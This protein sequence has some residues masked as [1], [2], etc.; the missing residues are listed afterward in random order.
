MLQYTIDG[1]ETVHDVNMRRTENGQEVDITVLLAD[2]QTHSGRSP[3][4]VDLNV[5]DLG[6]L[7]ITVRDEAMQMSADRRIDLTRLADELLAQ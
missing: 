7:V 4:S 1:G 6:M 5:D 2:M 3:V